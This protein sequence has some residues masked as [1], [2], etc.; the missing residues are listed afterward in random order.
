MIGGN[1]QMKVDMILEMETIL[2][3]WIEQEKAKAYNHT[4]PALNPNA[5]ESQADLGTPEPEPKVI[6]DEDVIQYR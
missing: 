5:K 3:K 2:N 1:E 6:Y 4:D